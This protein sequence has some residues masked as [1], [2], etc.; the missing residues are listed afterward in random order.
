LGELILANHL[1]RTVNSVIELIDISSV[2]A[3]YSDNGT[4]GYHTNML[5]QGLVDACL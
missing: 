4:C 2:Y 5:S 1:A 3:G